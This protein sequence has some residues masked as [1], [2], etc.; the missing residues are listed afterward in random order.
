ME[1][2]RVRRLAGITQSVL[3]KLGDVG[4]TACPPAL[5]VMAEVLRP[6]VVAGIVSVALGRLR[7]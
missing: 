1:A 6:L 4:R 5:Q 2:G 3:L 7:R